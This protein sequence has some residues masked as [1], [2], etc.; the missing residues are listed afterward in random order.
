M[1]TMKTYK[2]R[3]EMESD[4]LKFVLK[5]KDR[6]ILITFRIVG[7]TDPRVTFKTT[8]SL[9]EIR[10]IIKTIKDGH[11]MYETVKLLKEYTGERNMDD[12]F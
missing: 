3:A 9:Q 10:N 11:V 2:M 6:N 5:A 1:S 8:K 7:K 4:I 12:T